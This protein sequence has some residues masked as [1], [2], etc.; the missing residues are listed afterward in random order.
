VAD[1]FYS[2]TEIVWVSVHGPI[3]R[4]AFS[5]VHR[6]GNGHQVG[7]HV[8]KALKRHLPAAVVLDFLEFKYRFGNDIGGILRAWSGETSNGKPAI[9]PAAIVATGDT[10]K[11]FMSLLRFANVVDR[12]DVKCFSDVASAVTHLRAKL[13]LRSG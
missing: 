6:D 9:R 8:A 7:E 5:G 12:F 4:I 10:A 13:E 2:T 3:L 1:Y 11:A